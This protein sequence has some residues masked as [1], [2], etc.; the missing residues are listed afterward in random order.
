MSSVND[1]EWRD[2][3]GYRIPAVHLSSIRF[4]SQYCIDCREFHPVMFVVKRTGERR[5]VMMSIVTKD[6]DIC[7]GFE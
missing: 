3:T 4:L 7:N 1:S 5:L 6:G 2:R